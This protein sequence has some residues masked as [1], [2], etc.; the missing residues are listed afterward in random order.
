[1]PV[2]FRCEAGNQG[3]SGTH[4]ATWDALCRVTGRTDFLY[5]ADSKLAS[6]E[7]MEHI[8]YEHGRFVTVLPRTRREDELFR[9]WI[10]DHKPGWE[11]VIDQPNPRRK[12][13]P[14][15]RW[16]VFRSHLPSSEGWPVIWIFSTLLRTRQ[17]QSRHE[18]IARAEQELDDLAGKCLGPRPRKKDLHEIRTEVDKILEHQAVKEYIRVCVDRD[19]EH[20]Y[21]QERPG[22]PGPD[23]KFVRKTKARWRITWTIN[24]DKVAWDHKSDGMYPL[25][26]NDKS[27][28]DT[29][30][31]EAHKRQSRI[32][33][34]FETLKA[35]H[36]IAPALLKNEGRIEALFFLYFV[37]LLVEALIER[38][39]RRAM[40]REGIENL[41]LY[42]EGRE[43]PRPTGAQI[44]R[45]FGFVQRNVLRDRTK[46]QEVKVYEPTLTDLQKEVLRLLGVP[47]AAYGQVN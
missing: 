42:P 18:R 2:Q 27:L 43:D 30:V 45:L 6:R 4:I 28:S 33:R 36:E 15:D 21:R 9:E 26:T 47:I 8:A 20:K 40:E 14:R 38:E 24:H 5:V 17:E 1:V 37:A 22:R 13:G 41:P 10:Q 44:F 16:Y 23:T 29:Q 46:G 3:D 34:R 25:L 39:I 11:L 31:L 35:V 12:W 7:A 19:F 32:E